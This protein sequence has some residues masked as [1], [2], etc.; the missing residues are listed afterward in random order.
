MM[1]CPNC[2][3]QIAENAQ[4]CPN[5]GIKMQ[6]AEEPAT[7]RVEPVIEKPFVEEPATYAPN[8]VE[9]NENTAKEPVAPADAPA[10]Y[11]AA[12]VITLIVSLLT[13]CGCIPVVSLITSIVGL[14]SASACKKALAAG[15]LTLAK[16][17]GKTA[18]TMWVISAVM[19][20]ISILFGLLVLILS[21][22]SPSIAEGIMSKLPM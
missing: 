1:F 8:H 16:A 21:I 20:G 3:T 15:D 11:T 2:G 12:N 9:N 18:K 22:A 14:T 19:L 5:C 10:D 13:C 4:F 7:A 17:K 6:A